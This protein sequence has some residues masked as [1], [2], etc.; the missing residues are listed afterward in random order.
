MYAFT[1]CLCTCVC[2]LG[3]RASWAPSRGIEATHRCTLARHAHNFIPHVLGLDYG[4]SCDCGSKEA[5]G[6]SCGG[7]D[8]VW[9]DCVQGRKG[10]KELLATSASLPVF[11]PPHTLARTETVPCDCV[12][13]I[14]SLLVTFIWLRHLKTWS[15][16]SSVKYSCV[17]VAT[18][19]V[20]CTTPAV[21]SMML[22]TPELVMR[23]LSTK[24]CRQ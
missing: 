4:C 9:S 16:R 6:S 14:D 1:Y 20:C 17:S 18:A 19:L 15:R 12:C 24:S 13:P 7:R 22:H 2:I 5:G 21:L 23:Q 8:S 11:D 3:G 10:M